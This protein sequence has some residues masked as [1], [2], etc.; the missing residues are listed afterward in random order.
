[1]SVILARDRLTRRQLLTGAA[2]L[3][4]LGGGSGLAAS[5]LQRGGPPKAT[6]PA[7]ESGLTNPARAF[8]SRPDLRPPAVTV[9]GHRSGPEVLFL[10]PSTTDNQDGPQ[11]GP[12]SVD[13]DGEPIFFQPLGAGDW[14]ANVK[15]QTFNGEQVLT[16]WEGTVENGYGQGEAVIVDNSYHELARVRAAGGR[17]MDL[18]EFL[19]T[20]EGTA[21]FTCYPRTVRTDLRAIGGSRDATVLE[22]AFQ[23]VDVRSGRLVSEWNSLAHIAPQESYLQIGDPYDYLHLNSLALTADGN[24]L[25]SGRETWS[26]YRLD[27]RTGAVIWR[28]GGKRSDFAMG[29]DARFAWQHHATPLSDQSISVFDDG[30]DGGRPTEPQ[31]RGIILAVDERRRTARLAR[32]YT[33]PKPLSTNAM[34]SMQVLPNGKVAVGWGGDPYASEFA[35]DGR[36]VA[37][38]QL[39]NG[40]YSYRALRYRWHGTPATTP[41]IALRPSTRSDT[42]TLYA[43]WNGA[44]HA[45]FWQVHAGMSERD[46]RPIG[47]ARRRGFETAIP[48]GAGGGYVAASALDRNGRRLGT[49]AAIRV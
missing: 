22:S 42:L 3:A 46:L 35:A 20:P 8:Y 32:S 24:L 7:S 33:H 47:V 23:E 15:V 5:L 17:Q 44:T 6:L 30:S 1:M 31:S 49:S 19:L 41:A 29:N 14:A 18:H 2:G 38:A 25:V 28:L 27:R 13:H 45:R 34:G 16:W 10:G 26:L 36:L 12:L 11:T 4:A 9:S 37:D 39:P 21:L 43:S 40:I 48:L